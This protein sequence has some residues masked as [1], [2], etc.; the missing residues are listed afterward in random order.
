MTYPDIKFIHL[1]MA[2]LSVSGFILRWAWMR[3][4]SPLFQHRLTRILPHIV[5]TLLLASAIW[6]AVSLQQYP[7]AQHWL[8]AKVVGLIAYII[9]G[10]L[11]LKRAKTPAGKTRAFVAALVVFAWIISVAFSKSA[12]GLLAFVS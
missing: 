12:W 11:A 2:L 4:G 7:L 5:D 6:L 1:S 9:L 3:R 10:T 8:S